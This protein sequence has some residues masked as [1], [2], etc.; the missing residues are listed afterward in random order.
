MSVDDVT[1]TAPG[2][3]ISFSVSLLAYLGQQISNCYPAPNTPPLLPSLLFPLHVLVAS[4]LQ[5]QRLDSAIDLEI[6]LGMAGTYHIVQY[7]VVVN[8][9]VVS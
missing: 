8:I 9:D 7:S 3:A 4:W 6:D 2:H 5:E 1:E